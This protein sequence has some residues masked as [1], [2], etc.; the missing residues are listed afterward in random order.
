LVRWRTLDFGVP[1]FREAPKPF[2][3][4]VD[5]S[6]DQGFSRNAATAAAQRVLQYRLRLG[7]RLA[8]ID[9]APQHDG[10]R[11]LTVNGAALEIQIGLRAGLVEGEA[12]AR[13]PALGQSRR[14]VDGGRCARAYPDFDR[15]GRTQRET[16][17]GDPEPPRGTDGFPGEQTPDDV[18]RFL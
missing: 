6:S 13:D 8:D 3:D 1:E 15:L 18:E 16:R 14:A 12:G 7:R 2:G 10:A 4:L 17:V 11:L 5:R 9:V